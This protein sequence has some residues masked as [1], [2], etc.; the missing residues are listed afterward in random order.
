MWLSARASLP[1]EKAAVADAVVPIPPHIAAHCWSAGRK[2]QAI[3]FF[4]V[5]VACFLFSHV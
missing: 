1:S 3:F 4:I 5:V 2:K